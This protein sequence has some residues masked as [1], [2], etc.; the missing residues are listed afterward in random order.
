MVGLQMI[1]LLYYY[2]LGSIGFIRHP[3][4]PATKYLRASHPLLCSRTMH[5]RSLKTWDRD[6]SSLQPHLFIWH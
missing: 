5:L 4:L 3:C 2:L 6:F 1:C